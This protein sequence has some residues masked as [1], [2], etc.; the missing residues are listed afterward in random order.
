MPEAEISSEAAPVRAG[1]RAAMGFIFAAALMDIVALGI[2]IPVLPHLIQN[3]AG[4]STAQAL[5]YVGIFGTVW[6]LMQFIFSPIVGTLSDHFGR[7]PVLLISIFGLG[8]DY[9]IMALA[10][11]LA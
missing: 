11:N 3:M 1:G 8:L 6:A 4:G 7:R 10:P 2:V 9:V 5:H